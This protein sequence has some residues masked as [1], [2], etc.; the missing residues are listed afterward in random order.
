MSFAKIAIGSEVPFDIDETAPVPE[1]ALLFAP[2]H[3]PA[4]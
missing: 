3:S 4:T 1:R 2:Q